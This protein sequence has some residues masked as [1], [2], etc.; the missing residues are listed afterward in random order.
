MSTDRNIILNS[1]RVHILVSKFSFALFFDFLYKNHYF[2]LKLLLSI[3]LKTNTNF[4]T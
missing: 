1:M 3:I 4:D 2:S